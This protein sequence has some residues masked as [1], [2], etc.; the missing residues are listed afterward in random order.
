MIEET[1]NI[2]LRVLINE[3]GKSNYKNLLRDSG[4]TEKEVRDSLA[5]LQDAE[6]VQKENDTFT[7]L[8]KLRAMQIAKAA[9]FG[10]DVTDYEDY[11]EITSKDKKEA[12]DFSNNVDNVKKLEVVKRKPLILKRNYLVTE[13]IDGVHEN[14]MVIL[15]TTNAMLYEHLLEMAKTDKKLKML[16]NMHDKAENSL[17]SYVEGNKK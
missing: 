9:Q 15:E 17:R 1:V 16:L 12:L 4:C 14:L 3:G 8:K 11:F 13:K 5:Y 6:L 2:M 10:I 7:L